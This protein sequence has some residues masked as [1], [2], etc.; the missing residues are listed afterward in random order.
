MIKLDAMGDVLRTTCV[1]PAMARAFEP[2]H[3]TWITDPASV[4]LLRNNPYIQEV[5][6]YG[7]EATTHLAATG[8]DLAVNL[9]TSPR[10]A[11]LLTQ[12]TASE[13]RGYFLTRRGEV[14][15]VDERGKTWWEMGLSDQQKKANT[16]TY[17]QLMHDILGLDSAPSR[18]V[19]EL[20]EDEKLEALQHMETMG[21]LP[22]GVPV[23]GL[24]TGAGGR[25]QY[26]RWS[27]QGYL[28]LAQELKERLRVEVLLLG[29]EAEADFNRRLIRACPVRIYSSGPHPIRRFAAMVGQCDV[30]VTGD[31]LGLHLALA[32]QR[33]VVS[34]FGPTSA[35]EIDLYGLGEK[36]VPEM[37]C[38]V[39]YLEKCD[40]KPACMDLIKVDQVLKSVWN[41]LEG[42]T[43]AGR[44][45]NPV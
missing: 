31:T 35:T 42:R 20:T 37:D 17:Q 43:W 23:I 3:L 10:A 25:W 15:P 44:P 26:K 12:V 9:D 34:L 27:H 22:S 19:L 11:A 36:L 24:N 13:F 1:L 18:Y 33:R 28:M 21:P 8:Y 14:M 40:K 4:P 5:L 32:T 41:Q 39:C 38:L 2:M 6:P 29:G 16:R 45:A 30:V 7:A